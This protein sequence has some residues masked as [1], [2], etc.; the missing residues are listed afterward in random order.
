M[1]NMLLPPL[2]SKRYAVRLPEQL[3]NPRLFPLQA[4]CLP[5]SSILHYLAESEAEYGPA[6]DDAL[7]KN[8]T[9]LVFVGHVTKLSS[10]KGGPRSAYVQP[11][12]LI[13]EYRRRY[14]KLRPLNKLEIADR[15]DQNL[16]VM[17]Y[18]LLPQMYRYIRSFFSRYYTWYNIQATVYDEM[19][20]LLKQS[21]RQHFIQVSLPTVMPSIADLRRAETRQTREAL[22][23]FTSNESLFLMDL[24]TW[25]G[26]HRDQSLLS[27]IAV[28]DLDRVNLIF[29]HSGAWF[30]VNL[31]VLN[32]WRRDVD[33]GVPTGIDP[34]TLQLR[35]LKTT[36]KLQ[37]SGTLGGADTHDK[38]ELTPVPV[39]EQAGLPA[40]VDVTPEPT[41]EEV[42]QQLAELDEPL[43]DE[44]LKELQALDH[45]INEPVEEETE[46]YDEDG[47]LIA[48]DPVSESPVTIPNA[49]G[50]QTLHERT[51]ESAILAKIDEL[52]DNGLYSAAEYRRMTKLAE[53]YK[54]LKNPYG[55]DQSLEEALKI[56]PADVILQK[57]APFP[58]APQILDKS[59]LHST[60]TDIDRQYVEK[61]LPKDVLNCVMS[62]QQAGVA[63]TGYDIERVVD[64][65]SDFEI[66]TV[67]LVPVVGRQSTI[68]FR[69]PR[70]TPEGQFL[71]N[72]VKYRLKKQRSDLPIRKVNPV[73]VALSSYYSKVFVEKSDRAVFNYDRWLVNQI[74]AKGLDGNNTVITNLRISDVADDS[75]NV[76]RVYSI[77]SAAVASFTS[78]DIHFFFDYKNRFKSMFGPGDGLYEKGGLV[79]VG[80]REGRPVLIDQNDIFY[81]VRNGDYEVLGR[82]EDLFELDAERA[83][84]PMA[85]IKLFSKVIPA[86]IL[87]SYLLGLD[88]LL[89]LL[90][91]TPRRV[92]NGQRLQ[93]M[94]D[95]FAV[96][97]LDESLVFSKDDV[98]ASLIMAGFNLYHATI[99]NY[100][101]HAFSKKDIYLNLLEA[102]GI[103]GRYLREMDLMNAMFV[104]PIT[105][106]ILEWMKE[107][108]DFIGLIVRSCEMLATRYVP[109]RVEVSE[110]LVEN[111]ERARGYERFAGAVYNQLV[112]SIRTYNA[113]TATSTATISM[114]PHDVWVDVVQDPASELINE[115]NP[116]HNIKEKEVMTYG[117]RGGRSRRSMVAD[118]RLYRKPDEGFVSEATVDSGDVAIIT[119]VPP[120]AKFTTVRG[121]VSAFDHDKDGSSSLISTAALLAPGADRDDPK[122]V[123]FINIQQTHGIA[124]EGY[125]A[126]P[127]RTGY[128]QILA[129]RTDDLFASAARKNGTVV[130]K[131]DKVLKVQ[132]DDGEVVTVELGRRFGSSMG[133]TLP[134]LVVSQFATGDKINQGDVLAYN[135]GFFEPLYE[136]PKQVAWKAGVMAKTAF[137]EAG[138]TLEDSSAISKSLAKKLGTQITKVR[139]ITV[140]FDQSVRNLVQPGDSV[141]LDT[142]LCTI[143]DSIT[144]RANLFDEQSLQTLRLVGAMTPQ[145]KAVGVVEK[146]EVYYHG[147]VEDMTESLQEIANAADRERKRHARRLNRPPVTGSVDQ[148]LRI[149]G[150]GLE[151]DQM[152][153][154]VYITSTVS[155]GIGDKAVFANQM[156]TVF[157][158]V[159]DGI[160]ETE[161]GVELDAI[162][163]YK[164]VQDRI[165]LSPMLI[166]TTNTL[167]R[168]IGERAAEIFFDETA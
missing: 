97:F 42:S 43:P 48:P 92:L 137:M 135:D 24:W 1:A 50:T 154:R 106:E 25:L 138:Y 117:G 159:L 67:T 105:R 158:H 55:G 111:M 124:A 127:L 145:A 31:G 46:R 47:V 87:L 38:P 133:T 79:L 37:E 74:R 78:N 52:A 96:R 12:P 151:L 110:G 80:K 89:E 119:Y 148:S 59:M 101:V 15:E 28:E 84:P 56:Q 45:L 3:M 68:R 33:A 130:E 13:N 114:N 109:E 66:H 69:L 6:S 29:R 49:V 57:T 83:P 166:G 64:A 20:V 88:N 22:E 32:K 72:G 160:H 16:I 4:L 98:K 132:Y 76:P 58:D 93:L 14:R 126:T 11:A 134:H 161:S 163:G 8:V 157:G 5:R 53:A 62:V 27:K 144:E 99:R 7:L 41:E 21:K 44:E 143:E 165:V 142:I 85:E 90:K 141:D 116:V 155:A 136:N 150:N 108:T 131:T 125:R 10:F 156:K 70:V 140:K 51:H 81:E 107:P 121:T 103:G 30:T 60:V 129:H 118:S 120:N 18:A 139:T 95:E 122:R 167:L 40:E 94:P 26:K 77:L 100:S 61:V 153:I 86:G 146:V 9:R 35:F 147:D 73:R 63:V 115:S 164:S 19:N 2:Y 36:V 152:A 91:L 23:P 113:R 123:N 17:N 65:V 39:E 82:A 102:Y 149:E 71:S 75:I 162:F 54:G 104:D 168:V 128:E 34:Q 112:R